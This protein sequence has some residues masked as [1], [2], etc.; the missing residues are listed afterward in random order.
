MIVG[1]VDA[2]QHDDEEEQH[3]DGPGVDD[4]LHG[5]QELGVLGD[6]QHG[7]PEQGAHQAQRG[8]DGVARADHP[9]RRRTRQMIGSE[10]EDHG[11]SIR[12]C[13]PSSSSSSSSASA[14]CFGRLVETVEL[15]GLLVLDLATPHELFGGDAWVARSACSMSSSCLLGGIGTGGL[16][17]GHVVV[18]WFGCR[19]ALGRCAAAVEAPGVVAPWPT[20]GVLDTKAQ[21]AAPPHPV[22]VVGV[23]A[24]R[25]GAHPRRRLAGHRGQVGPVL[26]RKLLRHAF[27]VDHQLGLGVD[28][29]VAVGEGELEQLGLGDGLGGT[30]LH[31]QVA[32]DAAQ[33]VD[34]IDEAVALARRH[35]FVGRVVGA[36]HV[37]ATS[38]AHTGAQ[39]AADALLHAVLVAVQHMAPVQALGL[40]PLATLVLGVGKRLALGLALLGEGDA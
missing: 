39:L 1:L 32:V 24:G 11:P 6:E 4:D 13:S 20:S 12:C 36:A 18:S 3:H 8:V 15:L 23:A 35:R 38:G 37:D 25:G 33:V 9:E 29:V 5:G 10:E 14:S 17:V 21:L 2:Q 22:D 34:L 16:L 27:V 28:G 30:R 26:P 7:H 31:A 19:T 40:G